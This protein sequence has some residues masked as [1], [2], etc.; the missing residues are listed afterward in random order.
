MP[1]RTTR[2]VYDSLSS[3]LSPSTAFPAGRYRST[4]EIADGLKRIRRI[5]LTEGIPEVVSHMLS[6]QAG[7]TLGAGMT[8]GGEGERL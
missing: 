6:S 2:E 8:S 1:D 4:S 3:L 5:I 7:M